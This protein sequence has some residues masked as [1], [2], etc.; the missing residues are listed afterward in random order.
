[1]TDDLSKLGNPDRIRINFSERW[2]R[3]DWCVKFGITHKTL[4]DAV[5]AVG[6]MVVDVKAWLIKRIE[7]A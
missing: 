2:E 6:P 5:K 7:S 1:M 3:R 4:R